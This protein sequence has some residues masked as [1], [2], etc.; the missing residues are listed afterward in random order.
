MGIASLILGIVSLIIGLI[1]LCGSIALLPAIAGFILGIIDITNKNK[2]KKGQSIAGLIMSVIAI[3]VIIFWIFVASGV[4]V[5]TNSNYTN[6]Y[7]ANKQLEEEEKQQKEE[8]KKQNEEKQKIEQ[9]R[10]KEEQEKQKIEQQK[11]KEEQEKKNIENYKAGCEEYNYKEIARN[12]EKYN[13]KR[14][15]FTGEVIQVQ[16]GFLNSVTLRVN[17]TKN[18]YDFYEDTIYCTYTYSKNESKI[19]ED[20]IITL[21]GECKGDTTYTSVLGQ[22]ITIPK[23]EIRYVELVNN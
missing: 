1:P 12:P 13:G 21:Y 6:E 10:Q 23:V 9:Q 5:D 14:I 16:E 20:D 17:V 8:L 2:R 22:S 4:E 19:L 7:L 11:Q 18:K 3:I 15:K